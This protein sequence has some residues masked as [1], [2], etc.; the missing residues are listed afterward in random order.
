MARDD[1]LR[2]P[3]VQCRAVPSRAVEAAW[4]PRVSVAQHSPDPLHTDLTELQ[5]RLASNDDSA[6]F[7]RL[8][9]AVT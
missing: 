7:D 2:A 8:P 6:N 4:S 1:A 9:A 5:F 3:A